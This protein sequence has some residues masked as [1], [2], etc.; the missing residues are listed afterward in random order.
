HA[1]SLSITQLNP[2]L[3]CSSAAVGNRKRT[4]AL[5]WHR[6]LLPDLD[7][8]TASKCALSHHEGGHCQDNYPNEYR[9]HP[10]ESILPDKEP[11]QE[12]DA[13]SYQVDT[14]CYQGMRQKRQNEPR[15]MFALP[16]ASQQQ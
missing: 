16:T 9:H 6:W 11:M 3:S 10:L 15:Y 2:S 1:L 7:H 5:L 12:Q 8:Q 14:P 4:A 13:H